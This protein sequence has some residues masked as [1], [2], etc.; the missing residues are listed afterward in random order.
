MRCFILAILALESSAGFG[1]T[2]PDEPVKA[3]LCEIIREPERFNGKPVQVRS[4]FVSKFEWTGLVDE[5][6]AAKVQTG[7]HHVLD[8]LKPND[9]EYAFTT[10]TDDRTHPER[11]R[12][13]PIQLPHSLH[14]NEDEAYK[15][16]RKYADAKFRWKDGG[17]C[18]DCPLYRITA[19]VVARFDH[20]E[21]QTVAERLNSATKAF[22]HS[23]GEPNAPLSRFVLQGVSDV[24]AIPVDPSVYSEPKRRNVSLEEAN[25][26]VYA[27]LRTMGCRKRTCGLDPHDDP[28]FPDFYSFQA[29]H[30]NPTGSPNMG[31]FKVDPRTGDVWN[32]VICGKYTSAALLAL[33]RTVRQRIGLTEEEYRKTQRRG[34][35]CEPGEQPRSVRTK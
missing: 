5:N 21:T 14:L 4:E 22:G 28:Y 34:P 9:G 25:D 7:G 29:L 18:L 30:D 19:T 32:G 6:C 16:F 15:T 20:F 23:A 24:T 10:A 26:L 13:K 8:D 12:W 31:F 1:Q 11:L 3:T 35:M 33:Q 27:Y 2:K 17:T